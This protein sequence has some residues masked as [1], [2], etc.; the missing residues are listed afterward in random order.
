MYCPMEQFV[1][2][3]TASRWCKQTLTYQEERVEQVVH[4]TPGKI[5]QY[6]TN[7]ASPFHPGCYHFQF[8][9]ETVGTVTIYIS[10]GKAF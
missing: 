6:K 2:Y 7:S 8:L 9:P 1:F 5:F 10:I 3:S 4:S